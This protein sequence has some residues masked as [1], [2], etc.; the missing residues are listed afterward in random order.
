MRVATY[1]NVQ[2]NALGLD[3][4][5]IYLSLDSDSLLFQSCLLVVLIFSLSCTYHLKF[6]IS[7]AHLLQLMLVTLIWVFVLEQFFSSLVEQPI[8]KGVVNC[9]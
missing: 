2:L 7:T 8:Q 5:L 3:F 1:F 6:L 9:L 4:E